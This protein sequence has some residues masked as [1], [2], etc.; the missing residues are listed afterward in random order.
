MLRHYFL[1]ALR[2]FRKHLSYS[3]LNVFGLSLGITCALIIFLFVYDELQYDLHHQKSAHI[4]RL[5]AAYHLPN[6]GGFEQYA[7]A[8]PAIGEILAKDYPEIKEVVRFHRMQD[9]VVETE[10]TGDRVYETFFA[11]DSNVF[12]VFT[13]PFLVGQP[14][15]SLLDPNTVVITR[16]M[17]MKYFNREDVVG[18]R[19]HL[20][21]DSIDLKITGVIS[22]YPSNTHL[23]IDFFISMETYRTIHH[24]FMQNWWNYSF[25]TYLELVPGA[26]ASALAEKIQ[27]IS[28][29]YIKDQED[30][31]GYRQEYSLTPFS[32]I[33]L[34]SNLR[35][36]WEA[37]SRASY[38]YIFLAIGIFILI[39]A[40]INFMNLATARSAL[41]AKEIGMRKVSGALRHQLIAQFF[42]EA[43]FVTLL[44]VLV[45]CLAVALLL[46]YVNTFSGKQ[47]ELLS[48]EFFGWA[49]VSVTLFV[50]VLAGSYPSIFLSAFR[51]VETIKGSFKNSAKGNGLRKAL[52]VFQFGISVFLIAGTLVVTNQLAFIR[53]MNLG[54]NKDQIVV[55]PTRLGGQSS[56]QF[57]VVREE[58]VKLAGVKGATLSSRVPGKELGNN[59]VR[60]GWD[61]N[62]AW[63]D[64][65]FLAVDHHFI[66]TY[67]LELVAGRSFDEKFPS[68]VNEA[69]LVNES[70]MRR[71]GFKSPQEA[72]GQKLKWQDRNGYVIGVLKDFHF[73]STNVA[74]EPFLVVMNKPWSLGY[75]S[76]KLSSDQIGTTI[77]QLESLYTELLPGRIFEF[78]FLDQDFD[79]Q[80]SSEENFSKLVS[81]FAVIAIAI[82]CLGLY[83]LAMFMGEVRN[84]EVG[85]RKVL[86][87]SERSLLVLLTSDFMKLVAI[88][89][90]LAGP[91][92]YWALGEWLTSFPYRQSI[93]PLLLLLA[94]LMAFAV[95]LITISF[96][97]IKAARTNPVKT[98]ARE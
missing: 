53:T 74:I 51:P 22:N 5:N 31:S 93:N 46:P 59:V 58:V 75:L 42:G 56:E 33:H 96:Q 65:R 19:L 49:L 68:D 3:L 72:I 97:A 30:G 73:M 55:I 71:L 85:I 17:A 54:F 57:N 36:E 38:V 62:A 45:A 32:R 60:L 81:T 24:V 26:N 66:D 20:P 83:G 84:K 21:Q 79:R 52:V 64:M 39:I 80:Y 16:R 67:A 23:K 18:E 78:S 90:A 9:V 40:C 91:L 15:R 48:N 4:Y 95:A 1:I 47:L 50:A 28:R 87:A 94:G 82:A 88:A 92:V 10:G 27:F 98:I 77:N 2:G 89:C 35:S 29:Q 12:R 69:F 13:F 61:D 86:G 25:A 63:S 6:N 44:A 37:N 14:E 11:A 70:G 7:V 76:V 34:Y 8:G 41:R 43:L